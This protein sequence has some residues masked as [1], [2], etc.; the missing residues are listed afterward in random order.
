M[1]KTDHKG[2][3]DHVAKFRSRN[4]SLTVT[5]IFKLSANVRT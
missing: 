3:Q 5:Y 2:H 1:L 4:L